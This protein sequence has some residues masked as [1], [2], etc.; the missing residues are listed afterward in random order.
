MM[1]L[2]IALMFVSNLG[3]LLASKCIHVQY[4]F[5]EHTVLDSYTSEHY[6]TV[7][8]NPPGVFTFTPTHLPSNTT[9]LSS[10]TVEIDMYC[11]HNVKYQYAMNMKEQITTTFTELDSSFHLDTSEF[12]FIV[13]I[14]YGRREWG[15]GGNVR[16]LRQEVGDNELIGSLCAPTDIEL[17]GSSSSSS[18]SVNTV[19]VDTVPVDTVPVDTMPVNTVPVD[20]VPVDTVPVNT[21]SVDT[22]PVDTVPVD[23]VPVDTMPVDTVSVN[24]M[25]VDTVPVDTVPVD[26]VP[27]DISSSGS[28]GEDMLSSSGSTC[29]QMSG[30]FSS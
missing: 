25:P 8:G 10:N 28:I 1:M 23:T 19:P 4:G 6:C 16:R 24:T 3:G 14:N 22:V 11:A 20:T 27:V 9:D 17:C 21:V 5:I 7:N 18:S 15:S 13:Y 30:R 26:T 2:Y 12:Y 29:N